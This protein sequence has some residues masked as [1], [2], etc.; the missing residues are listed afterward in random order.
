MM[1]VNTYLAKDRFH[2]LKVKYSAKT[3]EGVEIIGN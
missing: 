3:W 2:V 1:G